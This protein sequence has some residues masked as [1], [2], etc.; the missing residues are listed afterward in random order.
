MRALWGGMNA[1]NTPAA[2]EIVHTDIRIAN[3]AT[4]ESYPRHAVK[5]ECS[6]P[7]CADVGPHH[8]TAFGA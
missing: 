8:G 7:Q 4:G 2:I 5:A 1:N 6:C 3:H